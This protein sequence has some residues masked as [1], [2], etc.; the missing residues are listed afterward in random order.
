MQPHI[1]V[2]GCSPPAVH[3]DLE[4]AMFVHELMTVEPVTVRPSTPVKQALGLLASH[5]VTSLPVVDDDQKLEG[6][7][8]E[9]DL[10]KQSVGLDPRAQMIPHDGPHNAAPGLVGE[11]MTTSVI[12]VREHTD[13]A[14]AVDLMTSTGF[15]SLP[16][17]D[18]RGRIVGM[19]SR[20][21]VVKSLAREDSTLATEIEE[22]LASLGH[23]SWLVEVHDGV[24]AVNGPDNPRDRSLARVAVNTVSGVV[25]VRIS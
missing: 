1:G 18:E 7:V 22:L 24:V 17:V 9:A 6:V 12:T 15:K 3:T 11:V 2:E 8:S 5:G 19:I 23:D 20:S 14:A 16:V 10:I 25:D 21:D 4:G 13:L